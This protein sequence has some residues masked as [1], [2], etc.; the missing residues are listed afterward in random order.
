MIPLLNPYKRVLNEEM[1]YK[2]EP[3]AYAFR[4]D[5]V[6]TTES[7]EY[8][9]NLLFIAARETPQL[10]TPTSVPLLTARLVS[11]LNL[12]PRILNVALALLG[13]KPHGKDG[14]LPVALTKFP[15]CEFEG[16][17][18]GSDCRGLQTA[19]RMGITKVSVGS[20]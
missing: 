1:Q 13:E 5:R 11:D 2:I 6:P 9:A 4:M 12:E 19:T 14:W 3:I 18:I 7:I 20:W 16:T 8:Q 17:P 10:I 15:T